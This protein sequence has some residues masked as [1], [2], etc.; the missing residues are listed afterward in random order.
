MF[1]ATRLTFPGGTVP[2]TARS[3]MC[4]P[5]GALPP[6]IWVIP[7]SPS[8]TM[9]VLPGRSGGAV[10]VSVEKW[11]PGPDPLPIIPG[12]GALPEGSDAPPVPPGPGP[13]PELHPASARLAM[14]TTSASVLPPASFIRI[15]AVQALRLGT[16]RVVGPG[17]PP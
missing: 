3:I 17:N 5:S 11:Y 4:A 1:S 13:L 9:T 16:G 7:M 6:I 14:A 12:P 15:P 10:Q 2:G 8:V